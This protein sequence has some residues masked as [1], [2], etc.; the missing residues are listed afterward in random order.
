MTDVE[1][2][3]TELIDR[4]HGATG[5][6]PAVLRQHALDNTGLDGSVRALVTKA[7][8]RSHEVTD[9]DVAAA[10]SSGAGQRL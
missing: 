9:A 4:V 7:A 8:N 2:L 1:R 10:R 6:A 5:I 3:R